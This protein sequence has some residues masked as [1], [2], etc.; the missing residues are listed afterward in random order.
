M[1]TQN[2]R[3]GI[4]VG[5][6]SVGLAAIA[7]DGDGKPVTLLNK[8]VVIHDSGLDP[9]QKSANPTQKGK[10]G[11]NPKTT[12]RLKSSGIARRTRRLYRRRK[13]R[14]RE[15]DKFI[16]EDLGYPLAD[17]ESF[18]DPYEP[19]RVRADLSSFKLPEDELPEAM[20]IALRHMA[21]HRGWRSPYQ[22]VSALHLPEEQSDEFKA[23]K[24]RIK[25]ETG[26]IFPPDVTPAEALVDLMGGTRKRKIRGEDG[27]LSGKLRQSDNA[28]ELRKIADVQ[29]IDE[30]TLN[31]IID[32]VFASKSPKGK[33]S[34]NAG[35]DELPGQTGKP[36]AQKADIAFQEFRIV[37]TISNLRIKQ[38]DQPERPLN[39]EE[40][41]AI[42]NLLME[43]IPEDYVTW[44]N[45]ADKLGI[46]RNSLQGTAK[47]DLDG[48]PLT[49]PPVN[50]TLAAI[51]RTKN[52]S[53]ID[54]W[55]DSTP[56]VQS[57]LVKALSN[58]EILDDAESGSEQVFEFLSGL[59][60]SEA[61]KL[62]GIRL[63]VGRASYSVDSLKRLTKRMLE[64]NCDLFEARK[65]E[66][67]VPDDWKPSA[68]PIYAPV[69]NPAVDRVLKIVNRWIMAAER[70]WGAPSQVNVEHIRSG[71][72]SAKMKEDYKHEQKRRQKQ[73]EAVEAE[74]RRIKGD[75]S[76]PLRSDY[77]RYYAV[78]RQNCQCA[79]CGKTITFN[80]CEM[81]HIVPRK[82]VGSTNS[83]VN[84]AAVC[85]A[86]NQSK[87]NIPFAV[88]ATQ[89]SKPDVSVESAC[90]RVEHWIPSQN[91]S[92]KEFRMFKKQVISRLTK[93]TEDPEID[94]RSL[95]SVAWMAREL[96]HRIEY[97]FRNADT[98]V[99]VYRGMITA[100]ARKASQLE[101]KIKMIGGTGKTRFDRRHHVID[102][103]TI[104]MITP[105]ISTI[106]AERINLR[107]A[108]RITR[109]EE[110]WKR[111]TGRNEGDRKAFATW[112][113]HMKKLTELLNK[114][115]N[116]DSIPVIYPLRLRLPYGNAH[117]EKPKKF[118]SQTSKKLAETWTTDD[119][120]RASTPQL[121]VALTRCPDFDP[122]KGLPANPARTIRAQG[123]RY[124]PQDTIQLF[125]SKKAAIAVRNGYAGIGNTIH[126]A[127]IYRLAGKNPT[128]CMLRV[129]SVD[130]QKHRDE[131]LFSVELPSHSISVRTCEDKLRK[132]LQ[133][134]TAEY[135]GWITKKDELIVDTSDKDFHKNQIGDLLKEYPISSF[136]VVGYESATILLLKPLLLAEEGIPKDAGDSVK[137]IIAEKGWRATI[138]I[139][140]SK[141]K[142]RIIRRNSLGE[143]RLVS[144]SGLPVSW[145]I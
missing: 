10:K 36:R 97:Y 93:T 49:R 32:Y 61:E 24:E 120:D 47:P 119:I 73:N 55:K 105:H 75:T 11:K 101:G 12:T 86:C 106:L 28:N 27:I 57:A 39:P 121:W 117:D 76:R 78:K 84:L 33:A 74:I 102:A 141:G 136:R 45:V 19:W 126:H 21:R 60:D 96:H 110:T 133:N 31:K 16:T 135:L 79:Y 142:P 14:L 26:A 103:A 42:I 1:E 99:N 64:D 111:Y 52:R 17:L 22:K 95:E 3:I 2:Y 70:R 140:L 145:E 91:E 51:M 118:T 107:E 113:E 112:A 37:S 125:P 41:Q 20:S 59:S 85:R 40:K 92:P 81:D 65:R 23:L 30:E 44:S 82:G 94:A 25:E 18:K 104:A 62:D 115:L 7:V 132:A 134:G 43:S 69:G 5:T 90:E 8:V 129:F 4:D 131:D 29:G 63:P 124:A 15:L 80:N 143:E 83:R 139:L 34:E 58:A 66:F 88:W 116:S 100:Q 138:N 68:E 87:S 71:F 53:L 13:Q 108:Q 144:H 48:E 123:I 122:Q 54:F 114:A 77:T 56:D 127:R 128:Y 89:T 46:T 6:N 137:K 130:L 9:T 67:N 50:S 35:K 72:S 109:Q 98:K 38:Q